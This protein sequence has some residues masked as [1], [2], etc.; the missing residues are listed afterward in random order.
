MKTSDIMV[1]WKRKEIIARFLFIFCSVIFH[2]FLAY[3]FYTEKF[4][5]K[6]VEV[7]KKIIR[8]RPVSQERIVFPSLRRASQLEREILDITPSPPAQAHKRGE[9]ERVQQRP[10]TGEKS[11]A[12]KSGSGTM[13]KKPVPGKM[14]DIIKRPIS[15]K[16]PLKAPFNPSHYLKVETVADI[17]RRLEEEERAKYQQVGEVEAAGADSGDYG[18]SGDIVVD[19]KGRAYFQSKGYDISPWAR[20]VVAVINQNWFVFTGFDTGKTY[21][22]KEVGITVTFTRDGNVVGA[23]LKRPSYIQILDQSALNAV[24]L[25]APFPPLPEQYPDERLTAFFL[26]KYE[27]E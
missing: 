25:S 24:K 9:E 18:T 21:H 5:I 3:Y 1:S 15:G 26:F 17:L 16:K 4:P 14:P 27:H 20:K 13:G 12:V 11:A 6:E 7:E 19:R 10:E 2:I 8:V 22:K 23:E